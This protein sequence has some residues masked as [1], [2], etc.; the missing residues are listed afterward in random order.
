MVTGVEVLVSAGHD[1]DWGP[2][3]TLGSG[4]TLVELL[5]DVVHL[6]IPCAEPAVRAALARLRVQRLL[7]GYRGSAPADIDSAVEA[8]MRIQRI[9]LT[10]QDAVDE[11]EL[12]PLVVGTKGRGAYVV[13]VLVTDRS[14][15]GSQ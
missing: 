3:L 2:V 14:R 1:P 13:D 7:A 5:D 4:G 6:A 11:I 8:V 10:H 12:N 15:R 9:L